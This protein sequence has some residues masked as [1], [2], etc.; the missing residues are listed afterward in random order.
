LPH[1]DALKWCQLSPAEDGLFRCAQCRQLRKCA[2]PGGRNCRWLCPAQQQPQPIGLLAGTVAG[3]CE[4]PCPG[5]RLQELN[6]EIGVKP[7][8]GCRCEAIRQDMNR[9]GAE[10]CRRER[11][12]LI[13]ELR[14]NHDQHYGWLDDFKAWR[15]LKA[16]ERRSPELAARISRS[17][18]HSAI[19]DLFDLAVAAAEEKD[20]ETTKT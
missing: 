7:K 13:R 9:L 14:E 1:I 18:V 11:E 20:H 10:G 3:V 17:S 15:G 4:G 12:R 8:A 16:L 5:D 19:A 6:N 2:F